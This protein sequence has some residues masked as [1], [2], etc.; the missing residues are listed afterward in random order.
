MRLIEATFPSN[1]KDLISTAVAA[2]KPVHLRIVAGGD[3]QCVLRAL[4]EP[5][6]A[7]RIVDA[8][9]AI[10]GDTDD[11]RVVVLPVEAT[12]PRVEDKEGEAERAK[13][14]TTALREEIYQDVAAGA[15]VNADFLVLTVLSAIVAGV[16][17]MADNVAAVIG[18]MVIAPLLGPVL[19]FSFAGALGDFALMRRSAITSLTGLGL[20]MA[21]A[22]CVGLVLPVDLQSRE[23]MARTDYGLDSFALALASGAAAALS[24]VTGLSSALVGVMV[25]VALAPPAVAAGLFLGSGRPE[26][27]LAAATLLALNIVSVIFA[28]QVVYVWKGVRPRTWLERKSAERSVRINIAIWAV[29]LAALAALAVWTNTLA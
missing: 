29:L 15:R 4:C 22:L 11:W 20:G 24:I 3:A 16:G 1:L 27:A 17:L 28:A 19:A 21:A 25:A 6:E 23:L 7:Q 10:C 26:L 8:I 12:A 14:R 18:A 5:G 13:R 9:Q 2:A